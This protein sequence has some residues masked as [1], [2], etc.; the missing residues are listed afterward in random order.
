MSRRGGRKR[1]RGPEG[2]E[3]RKRKRRPEEEGREKGEKVEKAERRIREKGVGAPSAPRSEGRDALFCARIWQLAPKC[4]PLTT[5]RCEPH[6]AGASAPTARATAS[7]PAA[8]RKPDRH[9][10]EPITQNK[11]YSNESSTEQNGRRELQAHRRRQDC[12]P[13]ASGPA[14]RVH[15]RYGHAAPQVRGGDSRQGGRRQ[16]ILH[17]RAQG[18]LRRADCRGHRRPA[19]EHLHG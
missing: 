15:L 4:V 13:V 3:G 11:A 8:G 5:C 6:P 7:G 2:R 1:K 17:A 9:E 14:P 10:T 19:E 16:G 18:R 12:G